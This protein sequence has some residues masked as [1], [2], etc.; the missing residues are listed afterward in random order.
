MKSNVRR[1]TFYVGLTKNIREKTTLNTIDPVEHAKRRKML[2]TCFTD[3]S[4]TAISTF[5]GQHID[6]WHEIFLGEHDSTT[7]WSPSVNLGERLDHLVFDIM[8]DLSFGRSFNIKEPGEN[9][10]RDVQHSIIQYLKFYYPVR[11]ESFYMLSMF[12]FHADFTNSQ[13]RC[14]AP[15]FLV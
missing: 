14:A 10:L 13:S 2:N 6:R 4:V 1:S 8:G 12:C 9:P 7:D 5:M 11:K 3:Q 15:L